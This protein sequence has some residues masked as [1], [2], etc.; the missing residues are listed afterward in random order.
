[1]RHDDQHSDWEVFDSFD[2]TV[3]PSK[4]RT[5]TERAILIRLRNPGALARGQ[6]ATAAFAESLAPATVEAQ[7]YD[8]VASQL[9]AAL[10]SKNVDAEVSIVE[11]KMWS[12]A[13]LAHVGSDIAFFV[14]GAGIV[15]ALYWLFSGRKK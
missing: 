15:G 11:P 12:P 14:G 5:E 10:L 7:V 1:M 4:I 6:G 3:L 8:E 2:G 13:G 9:D